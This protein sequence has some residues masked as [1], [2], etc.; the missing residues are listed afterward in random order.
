MEYD[1]ASISFQ[2]FAKVF[3]SFYGISIENSIDLCVDRYNTMNMEM[4]N[5]FGLEFIDVSK[6]SDSY[7]FKIIDKNKYLMAKI[8]YGI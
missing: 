2:Q 1:T 4:D 5:T 8:L 7:I 3:K 6:S